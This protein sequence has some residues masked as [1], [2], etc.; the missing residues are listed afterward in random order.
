[1]IE[2]A[3][4]DVVGP[5]VAAEDP[6][7][8]LDERI[9]QAEQVFALRS[10]DSGKL[11]LQG[12]NTLALLANTDFTGLI[13]SQDRTSKIV[14]DLS[15]KAFY[16]FAGILVLLVDSE[17]QTKSELGIVFKQRVRPRRR[18]VRPY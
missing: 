2:S 13:G 10:L 7:R 6:D 18:R 4:T 12:G 9:R 14:A 11:V 3:V 15:G 17:A 1:M 5:A 16:Q 8:L